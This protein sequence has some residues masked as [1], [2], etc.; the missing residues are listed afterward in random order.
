MA[1]QYRT[2]VNCLWLPVTARELACCNDGQ[3]ATGCDLLPRRVMFVATMHCT[4][5][6]AQWMMDSSQVRPGRPVACCHCHGV[7]P[8]PLCS[9]PIGRAREIAGT[10]VLPVPGPV[11]NLSLLLW[12]S[13]PLPPAVPG[14]RPCNGHRGGA[15][16]AAASPSPVHRQDSVTSLPA[17]RGHGRPAVVPPAEE[18]RSS[19]SAREAL[20]AV[21]SLSAAGP[22]KQMICT[23]KQLDL[24]FEKGRG[25]RSCCSSHTQPSFAKTTTASKGP[26]KKGKRRAYVFLS[27]TRFQ[28][29]MAC[30]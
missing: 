12:G 10:V 1:S 25:I 21:I 9:I 24:K 4:G 11:V 27:W 14:G 29:E 22:V 19:H 7:R 18:R 28:S 20:R 17:W 23:V 30:H 16:A 5:T 6:A 15:L 2:V 3:P 13:A 8:Q 26:K